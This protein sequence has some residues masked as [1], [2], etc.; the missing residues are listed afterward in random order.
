MTIFCETLQAVCSKHAFALLE[1]YAYEKNRALRSGCTTGKKINTKFFENFK[2]HLKI[3][4][5][6]SKNFRSDLKSKIGGRKDWGIRDW[7]IEKKTKFA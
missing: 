5:Q 2:S 3:S 1:S 7:G 4:D 6:I